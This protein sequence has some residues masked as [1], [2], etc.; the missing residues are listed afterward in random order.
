MEME[1]GWQLYFGELDRD[2]GGGGSAGDPSEG[3]VE[4]DKGNG[5]GKEE[6]GRARDTDLEYGW[7][8]YFNELPGHK[9]C[10]FLPFKGTHC[11][12]ADLRAYCVTHCQYVLLRADAE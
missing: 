8:L 9:V 4:D 2:G 5:S 10:D 7:R 12:G 3:K 1:F 6:G 11:G